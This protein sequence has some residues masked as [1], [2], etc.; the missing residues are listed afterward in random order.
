MIN[1]ILK[2]NFGYKTGERVIVL[3]DKLKSDD[4]DSIFRTKLAGNWIEELESQKIDCKLVIYD[5]TYANNANLPKN[6]FINKVETN[7]DDIFSKAD[8]V[9]ALTAFS[10][11]APLHKFA[12][13]HKLKVASM[14]GFDENMMSALEIDYN[15]VAKKVD[16]VY[17]KLSGAKS[18]NILFDVDNQ[19]YKLY[20][21]LTNRTPLK[22]DGFCL[23]SGVINLPSG[24]CFIAPNDSKNSKTKGYLPIYYKGKLEIFYVENNRISGC[25]MNCVNADKFKEDPAIGN[26]AEIAFGV[27]GDYGIKSSGKILLDEKLGFHIALGRSDHF[28]GL[29]G[30]DSF[31]F[32]KNVWHQ[33][34]VYIKEIQPKIKLKS[35]KIDNELIIKDDKYVIF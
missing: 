23:E 30:P 18:V 14:P 4:K 9:I 33:D 17:K 1:N 2:V 8:I 10:A 28:G 6:C 3:I 16:L 26:I 12:V 22:D 35:V 27:L 24:E 32:K 21:D 11:T 13:V 20:V 31:K 19:G 15:G 29:T 25:M 34:Y 5:A 7:F